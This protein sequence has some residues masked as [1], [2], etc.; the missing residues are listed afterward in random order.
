MFGLH[1]TSDSTLDAELAHQV[2]S[3]SSACVFA[4]GYSLVVSGFVTINQNAVC[5]DN[6]SVSFLYGSEL[7]LCLTDIL[8]PVCLSDD[9]M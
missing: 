9:H 6:C 1:F 7:G 3:A 2:A 8:A 5:T 4:A